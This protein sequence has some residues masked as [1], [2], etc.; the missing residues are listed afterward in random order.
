MDEFPSELLP[1]QHGIWERLHQARQHHRLPHA[2]L[3]SGSDGV[4]KSTFSLLFAQALLCPQPTPEGFACGHCKHCH[5]SRLGNHPDLHLVEPEADSKSGEI[6]IDTIRELTQSVTLTGQSGGHKVVLIRPAE[7]MNHSAAN[8]LLK[9]LEEPTEG[10]ILILLS[11]HPSRLL[12]TIRSRCQHY[13]FPQPEV[14]SALS[15]LQGKLTHGE[16]KTLLGLA[17]GAPLKALSLANQETLKLRDEMLESF[18][19]L[20]DKNQD[21]VKLAEDWS[22]QKVEQI[23]EWLAGWIIDMI[24]LRCSSQPPLLYNWDHLQALQARAERLNSSHLH[25]FLDQIYFARRSVE[26]N[27]NVQLMLESLLIEWNTCLEEA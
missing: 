3:F 13:T 20:G 12:P 27:L 23:L 25:R 7:R 22:K 26:G 19:K 21:P 9:T 16:P 11:S 18:L 1:W 4:G 17:G 2:L 6:K 8:S 14:A 24:R 15:W 10:K 5:L